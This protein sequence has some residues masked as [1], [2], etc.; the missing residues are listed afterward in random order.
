MLDRGDRVEYMKG[1]K[2]IEVRWMQ[3]KKT[4]TIDTIC[5]EVSYKKVTLELHLQADHVSG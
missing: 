1:M 4:L 2:R 5:S 3:V